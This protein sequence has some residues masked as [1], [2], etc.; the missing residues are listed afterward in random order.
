[1]DQ[2]EGN[3]SDSAGLKTIMTTAG[4]GEERVSCWFSGPLPWVG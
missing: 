4:S 1:M 2:D 3:G